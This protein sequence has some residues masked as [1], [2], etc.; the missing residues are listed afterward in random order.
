MNILL[1]I[2]SVFPGDAEAKI[3]LLAGLAA[4]A[5]VFVVWFAL[6]E[7]LPLR[8]RLRGLEARRSQLRGERANLQP[9]HP[10]RVK[11]IGVASEVVRRLQLLQSSQVKKTTESLQQAGGAAKTLS[12]CSCSSS[13]ACRSRWSPSSCCCSMC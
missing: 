7:P 4:F 9:S 10:M 2:V 11:A 12:C 5:A 13:C 6:L 8:A 1:G 3:A